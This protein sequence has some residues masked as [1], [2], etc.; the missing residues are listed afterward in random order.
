LLHVQEKPVNQADGWHVDVG[1][2]DDAIADAFERYNVV[3]W[4]SDVNP[5]QGHVERWERQYGDNLI[6]RFQKDYPVQADMRGHQQ[7]FTLAHESLVAAVQHGMLKHDGNRI[8][9]RHALNAH[10]RMN[11]HGMSFGK[12]SSIPLGRLT[13]TPRCC[14][15]IWREVIT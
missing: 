6:A 2:F 11:R 10:I 14:S 8:L 15:R 12:A 7:R 13:L 9:R 5:I 3:G 1:K 4:Y